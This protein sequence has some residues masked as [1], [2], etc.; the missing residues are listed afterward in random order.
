MCCLYLIVLSTIHTACHCFENTSLEAFCVMLCAG[1]LQL[2]RH[3][4][5][6][7]LRQAENSVPR[8]VGGPHDF[9]HMTGTLKTFQTQGLQVSK[10]R[11]CSF[12]GAFLRSLCAL[13]YPHIRTPQHIG[14][15]H[16]FRCR[17]VCIC[18]R[19]LLRWQPR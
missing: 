18:L 6:L 14:Q 8:A 2:P 3:L 1:R 15:S 4:L 19:D 12:T 10:G 11:F 17:K 13:W 7:G 16:E 9:R 5:G